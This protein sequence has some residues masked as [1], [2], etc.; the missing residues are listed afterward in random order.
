MK[1]PILLGSTSQPSTM[2]PIRKQFDRQVKSIQNDVLRMGALV[3]QSCG[4]AHQA[5]FD[6]NISIIDE[7]SRQDKKIDQLYRQIE[8]DCLQLIAL[9]SP[10][11]TDLRLIGALMQLI[12]DLE[13]I[14]DYAEDLAEIA[15]KLFPYDKSRHLPDIERMSFACRSMLSMSLVAL[16][17]LDAE[18]GLKIKQR[19]DE[20]DDGYERVYQHLANEQNIH[21]PVEPLLLL[22]LTI[23]S[24]ERMAD[25]ATNIGRR[26]AFIV[27]G[28]R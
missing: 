7:L 8:V 22:M 17:E 1:T 9:Q 19:D 11:A 23:R 13:R 18:E 5:L 16:T 3:E 10:V 4:L 26:V 12:R 14:G 24:I 2:R 28:Q 27:T 25:H 6:Q 15:V 20:V 21:G